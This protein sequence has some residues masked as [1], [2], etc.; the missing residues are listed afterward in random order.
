MFVFKN[1]KLV[2]LIKKSLVL[3]TKLN[4]HQLI[5]FIEK[6]LSLPAEGQKVLEEQL[7]E[8]IELIEKQKA[9]KTENIKILLEYNKKA[10]EK[11]EK[12]KKV[13]FE[14]AEKEEDTSDHISEENLIKKLKEI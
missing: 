9:V 13:T 4:E 11:I 6:A 7:I 3:K 12:F 5:Q 1:H 8:E 10:T 14:Q 2:E